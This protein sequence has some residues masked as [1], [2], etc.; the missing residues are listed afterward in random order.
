M[1]ILCRYYGIDDSDMRS[2]I[3]NKESKYLFLLLLKEFKCLDK[4][5]IKKELSIKSIRCVENNIKKAEEKLLINRDFREK[6]FYLEEK[7]V[8][9]I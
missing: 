6:Y 5:K 9:N 4:E 2:I 8:K 3:N 1:D 7:I